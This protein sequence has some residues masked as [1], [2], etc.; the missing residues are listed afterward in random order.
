MWEIKPKYVQSCSSVLGHRTFHWCPSY[1]LS[2]STDLDA[3]KVTSQSER[4]CR[5]KSHANLLKNCKYCSTCPWC[6]INCYFIQVRVVLAWF[7]LHY[8]SWWVTWSVFMILY[9]LGQNLKLQTIISV[10]AYMDYFMELF[11]VHFLA[12]LRLYT[13]ERS[14]EMETSRASQYIFWH[15]IMYIKVIIIVLEAQ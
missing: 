4:Q 12:S 2:V 8:W 6:F 10:V 14:W 11:C 1:F 13:W 9:Y 7:I 15:T 3:G 5:W